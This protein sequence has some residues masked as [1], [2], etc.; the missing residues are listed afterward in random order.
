MSG[1][2]QVIAVSF[3]PGADF[4]GRVMAEVDR[5][6]GRGVLRLLDLLFVVKG[7]DGTI[8]RLSVADDDDFGSLLE[9][10]FPE[11]AEGPSGPA[12]GNGSAGFDPSDALA[13][14]AS[15]PAGG[16]LA[17]LL[18][19]HHWAQ[20]LFAAIEET[21]GALLGEGF[22]AAETGLSIGA[23]IA[24][25]EEA[26]QVI[27]AAQAAEA[28]AM[29]RAMTA[30]SEADEAVAASHAIRA[31]AAADAIRALITA[32]LVEEAAAHEALEAVAAAGVIVAAADEAAAEAIDEDAAAVAA[33]DEAAA[34]AIEEDAVAV[35][36]ADED[37]AE[38]IDEDIAAAAA[39]E[40]I[41]A[42]TVA[43]SAVAVFTVEAVAAQGLAD[44]AAKIAA[45]GIT[46]AEA[47]VLR[48]LPTKMTFAVI[49][50]KLG[51]TR[52]AA[53]DR[54]ER[55]YK[56]L[57]VHSRAEAVNRARQLGLIK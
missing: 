13:L 6:Q 30:I 44:A 16:A 9:S 20:P 47:R 23:E 48:Y 1:P 28:D 14:A 33:A 15:L 25:M 7:E 11:N 57:G 3:D 29:L 50:A 42:E 40:E 51:I 52:S 4:E 10:L 38:A 36:V 34:E 55:L 27:S 12:A 2:L 45:A 49:A 43:E 5:L 24:A 21:G 46:T 8:E 32:G 22:L 56:K 17:L 53:K 54:A 19:E 18:I 31:A 37:A 41:T 35:T 26:A 39:A